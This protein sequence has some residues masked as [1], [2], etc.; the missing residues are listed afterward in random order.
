MYT[1]KEIDKKYSQLVKEYHSEDWY[2]IC[3]LNRFLKMKY[4][5]AKPNESKLL[6]E[7]LNYA[8]ND[9]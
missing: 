3:G 2:K 1:N 6:F 7:V 9:Y 8:E 4:E 5:N